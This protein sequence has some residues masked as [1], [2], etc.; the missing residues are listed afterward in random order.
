VPLATIGLAAKRS[1]GTES[2]EDEGFGLRVGAI[3]AEVGT[4]GRVDPTR[5]DG[6][7]AEL[8]LESDLGL[9]DSPGIGFA[10]LGY[11]FAQRW[12]VNVQ[13][14]RLSRDRSVSLTRDITMGDTVFPVD[15]RVAD[16]FV[17]NLYKAH[18]TSW[19]LLTE[20][21]E[22]GLSAGRAYHRFQLR[23]QG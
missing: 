21:A 18:I 23:D 11:R 16:S 22:V 10:E 20:R 12:T 14:Q 6:N 3:L 9:G 17:T 15:A 1:A 19:P 2:A 8:D 7:G 4:M 5:F 13:Y